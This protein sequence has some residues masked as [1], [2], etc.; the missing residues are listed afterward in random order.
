MSRHTKQEWREDV[1]SNECGYGLDVDRF[2]EQHFG[3]FTFD[4][5]RGEFFMD[6]HPPLG[7]MLF[8][9]VAYLLGYDGKFSFALGK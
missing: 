2:D 4:Y 8:S 6:V 1:L 3:G 5:L 9:L 7:K